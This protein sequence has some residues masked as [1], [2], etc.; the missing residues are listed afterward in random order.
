M[1]DINLVPVDAR[2]FPAAE[3]E[4]IK[5]N[6]FCTAF[7]IYKFMLSQKVEQKNEK[8]RKKGRLSGIY[9]LIETPWDV[10]MSTSTTMKIYKY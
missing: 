9:K 6:F 7:S 10:Q 5:V 4:R 3:R 1:V 2:M 8:E